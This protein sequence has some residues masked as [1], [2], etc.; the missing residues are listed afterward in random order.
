MWVLE[1]ACLCD[2]GL[3]TEAPADQAA[4]ATIIQNRILLGLI[5]CLEGLELNPE[6][7]V[8]CTLVDDGL[9]LE[10]KIPQNSILWIKNKKQ[11]MR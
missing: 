10:G 11:K 3:R 2:F 6:S 9:N 7:S 5:C 4:L 8:L 1:V